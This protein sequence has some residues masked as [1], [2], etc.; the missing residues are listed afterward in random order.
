M[1]KNVYSVFIDNRNVPMV[2]SNK[3]DRQVEDICYDFR[4]ENNGTLEEFHSEVIKWWTY[5]NKN[6]AE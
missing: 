6:H 3:A 5:F 1:F 4:I 2:L